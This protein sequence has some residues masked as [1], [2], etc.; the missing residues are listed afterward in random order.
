MGRRDRRIPGDGHRTTWRHS[1]VHGSST[2]HGRTL[3]ATPGPMACRRTS[4]SLKSQTTRIAEFQP[5]QISGLLQ[6]ADYARE[7]LH[8]PCGPLSFGADED[9]I[10][11]MVAKRMQRQQVLY[12]HGKQVQVIMLEGALRCRVVSAPTLAGQLDRLMAVSGLSSL[13]LGIIPFEAAVPVFPLSG[14][15]LYDDLVIV[16]SIVGEQQLAEPDDVA[17]YEKYLELLR[18]AAS[19]GNEAAAIIQRSLQALRAS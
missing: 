12:Q 17:R 16:E 10:D 5:S 18:E 14:F 11:Q 6:T 15:R 3:T 7:Y 9:A 1:G 2:R 8:L 19:T 13:E 4:W